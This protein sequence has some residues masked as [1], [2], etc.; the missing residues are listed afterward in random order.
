MEVL[1]AVDVRN[2]LRRIGWISLQPN[3]SVSVGLNDRTFVS[4]DFKA[5]NFVWNAYNRVTIQYLISSDPKALKPIKNPHLTFHPP[6][7]FQ[8]RAN[9]QHMLF[10]GIADLNIMLQQDG[11]VPWIR[12]VSK[13]VSELSKAGPSWNPDR[14][15][16]LSIRLGN[17]DCSIGLGVDFV[18]KDVDVPTED[19]LLSEFIDWQDYKLYVHSVAIPAQIATLSWYHQ[20]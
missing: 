10:E 2:E 16:I 15:K 19:L 3:G 11:R 6:I 5:K 20:K 14:T 4:P 8:L 18:R 17:E 1:L 12:F 7:K 9:G 13:P